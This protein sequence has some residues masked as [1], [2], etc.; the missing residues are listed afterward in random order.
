MQR[1]VPYLSYSDAAAAI[2][3]LVATFGL[4]ER[5]RYVEADGSVTHAELE[6]AGDCVFLGS[7]QPVDHGP[8]RLPASHQVVHVQVDDVDAHFDRACRGGAHLISP[9]EDTP[10]GMR[11]YRAEDLEGH[12]WIFA[13][14]VRDVSPHEWGAITPGEG[15]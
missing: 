13:Q 7:C 15:S 10:Y 4:R 12:R 3:W 8:G 5:L 9:L 14:R 6:L 1:I 11:R 2:G